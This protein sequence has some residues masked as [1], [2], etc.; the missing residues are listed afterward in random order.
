MTPE[1]IEK[2]KAWALWAAE[3]DDG[4]CVSAG[5]F[6]V[7][8]KKFPPPDTSKMTAEEAEA[9]IAVWW[10]IT[11]KWARE[12]SAAAAAEAAEPTAAPRPTAPLP[13]QAP[14]A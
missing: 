5:G 1:G 3:R 14:V 2:E 13:A 12:A 10:E 11:D 4:G 7:K 6:Y 9:A 8:M